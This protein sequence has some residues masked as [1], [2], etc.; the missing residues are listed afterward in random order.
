MKK[1]YIGDWNVSNAML[2]DGEYVY[3]PF[4]VP[5]EVELLVVGAGGG[6][7]ESAVAIHPPTRGGGGGA[8]GMLTGSF[9]ASISN[10]YSIT[11][12]NGGQG[13][14][15]ST[16]STSGTNSSFSGSGVIVTAFGGGAGANPQNPSQNK[17]GQNGGSGGGAGT[18]SGT[19]GTAGLETS[20]S[21][22]GGNFVAFGEQGGTGAFCGNTPFGPLWTGGGGGGADSPGTQDSTVGCDA[23]GGNGLQWVDGITYAKGGGGTPD[24]SPT[25][26]GGGNTGNPT[27]TNGANGIVKLRYKGL[28]KAT[29]GTITESDGYIYHTFTSADT[30]SV[31]STVDA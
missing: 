29:G 21:F 11:I 4:N 24:P 8:G 23:I 17:N 10:N 27:G 31:Y 9:S 6:G 25:N 13:G 15:A 16:V 20:G 2:L 30:F 1:L 22:S 18:E 28:Q 12:G 7:G 3:T 19:L 26:G 5:F 14:D